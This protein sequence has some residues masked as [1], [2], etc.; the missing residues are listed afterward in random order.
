[1]APIITHDE[2]NQAAVQLGL[3]QTTSEA[4]AVLDVPQGCHQNPS[5]L[6]LT[7]N[8]ANI[9]I[10]ASDKHYPV[11]KGILGEHPYHAA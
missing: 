5:G 8:P 1:M 11:C 10:G 3:P 2:C 9:A 6:W 4:T 7:I